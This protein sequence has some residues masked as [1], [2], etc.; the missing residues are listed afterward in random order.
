MTGNYIAEAAAGLGRL[1]IDCHN[2]GRDR[3]CCEVLQLIRRLARVS[4]RL[5]K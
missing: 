3:E 4:R 2:S 1:A 5:P